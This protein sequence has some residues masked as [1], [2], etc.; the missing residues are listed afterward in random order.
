M[1]IQITFKHMSSTEALKNYI[2]EKSAKLSRYV[3]PEA[4]C[5]WVL[6]VDALQHHA[7]ARVHGPHIDV[8]AQSQTEDM[9]SAIEETLERLEKQLRKHKE[10]LKDHLHRQ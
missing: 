10:I 3:S 7:D 8:F 1:K 2:H 9:Y 6:F 4:E 5:H